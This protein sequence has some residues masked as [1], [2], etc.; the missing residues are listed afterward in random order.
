M[1]FLELVARRQS[2]RKYTPKP[3]SREIIDRCLEA[4][5]LAPSA[6]NSQSWSFIIIDDREMVKKLSQGVFSGI[7]SMNSFAKNAA[8]LIIVVT[9]REKFTARLGGYFRGVK[10]NLIDIGIACEHFMLQAE[11]EGVGTCWLGWFNA[12]RVKKILSI[13]KAK[14]IDVLIS[15]GYAE[16]RSLRQKIRRSLGEIRHYFN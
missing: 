1:N 12:D 8:A 4:A 2:I 11:S 15:M 13:P 5:R 16:D 7:Y 6:C 3:V 10:Y 14:K 9:E